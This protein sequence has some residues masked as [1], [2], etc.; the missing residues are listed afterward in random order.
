MVNISL[1]GAEVTRF[2]VTLR[3][4]RFLPSTCP[5]LC[6]SPVIWMKMKTTYREL[7][8][9]MNKRN[10]TNSKRVKIAY[11]AC[12]TLESNNQI[13]IKSGER[14]RTCLVILAGSMPWNLTSKSFSFIQAW[15]LWSLV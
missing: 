9:Y 4:R 15:D 11:D 10:L 7:A 6:F 5:F 14:R 2:Q 8:A 12:R 13:N 1:T 3:T